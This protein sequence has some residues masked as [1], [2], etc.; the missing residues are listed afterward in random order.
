MSA[1]LRKR[2]AIYTRISRDLEGEGLGVKRQLED[3]RNLAERLGV[4]V[5]TEYSDNDIS[6]F[7]GRKRPD[8]HRLLADIAAGQ[9]DVVL[10]WNIDRLLRQSKEL[11][12]YMDLCLPRDVSTHEVTSGP[13]DLTTASGRAIAKTRGAWSQYESEHKAERIRRQKAQAAKSGMYLGGRV[14]WGW[15]REGTVVDERG[16]P[17]GG[18]I[19]L[20]NFAAQHIRSGTQAILAGRSLVSV[21]RDW[22]DSGVKS[23]SGT[24]LNT[25]QVKRILLRHRN[26]GLITFHNDVVAS[27]WPPIVS[28]R[29]FRQMEE[30]LKDRS[31][32]PQSE[33][34]FKYLLSGLVKCHCG[35][36]MTGFG[37]APSKDR[38]DYRRMYR[39]RV[40]QQGGRYLRGHATREMH[41]LDD[42]VTEVIAHYLNRE[43]VKQRIL[44]AA[45]ELA[46]RTN[47]GAS[48]DI[49]DLLAR[50][51]DLARLFAT[52]LIDEAQLI[53]GTAMVRSEIAE[54]ERRAAQ[55]G[56][57]PY[58]VEML[59]SS[60][61]G[62]SFRRLET[63][64]KRPVIRA[65]VE[66]EILDGAVPGA[67]F[68]PELIRFN[69]KS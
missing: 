60:N 34:K 21:T 62:D 12:S 1:K 26:A 40:H 29:E 31:F 33:A 24:M 6:A 43:D 17:H 64:D 66:V 14:P 15:K 7:S 35:E 16:R 57:E 55:Q 36:Y 49:T 58:L 53:E 39:C 52:G 2:A 54:L 45:S 56:G 30:K 3:C 68:N 18:R 41:R 37:A 67:G 10:C 25:T 59:M 8:Y 11:E 27:S 42:Y 50:R 22:A 28:L 47:Q 48:P 65:L 63:L 9:I 23:L 19:V 51:E 4:E 20:D 32:P 61:P 13:L 69:W 46:A 38:P 44:D 5:V